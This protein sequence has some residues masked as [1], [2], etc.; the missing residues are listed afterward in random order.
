MIKQLWQ[1][2]H[3]QRWR[4]YVQVIGQW[5]AEMLIVT[6][7]CLFT[8][9]VAT[10]SWSPVLLTLLGIQLIIVIIYTFAV[11]DHL[12]NRWAQAASTE[13]QDRFFQYYLTDN[14]VDTG[15]TMKVIHQDLATI[16]GLAVFY[17]TI[18]PTTLQLI[19]TGIVM[20]VTVLYI[21]PLTVLIPLLGIVVL[22]AGMGLLEGLG[23]KK[24]LAYINSFNH[25]G[26]RFLDDFAGMKTLIMYG[27][28]KRYARNF[29]QDSETFR[30]KTMGVLVYQLQTLT[31]MDFCLYGALGWFVIAQGI[32]VH[33]Q[34]L[35]LPE[36]TLIST[37]VSIW[38]IDFRKFGYFIHI[39]M[40]L[41]PKVKHLFDLTQNTPNTVSVKT[42]GSKLPPET[43]RFRGD[44][45]Y[46][47]PLV[48]HVDLTL[49]MGT[50]TGL[51]GPSG[52]GK[53]TLAAVL[54]KQLAPLAGTVTVDDVDLATIDQRDW[55]ASAAYLGPTTV[56]FDGTIADNILL[57][58][59]AAQNWE[60]QLANRH[61]CQFVRDLP[62]G[63]HT[64]V[65][66][67]GN[68]LS[69]G[70]RQQIALARAIIADK[71]V[72]VF[73]E[74]TANVDVA[75]AELMLQAITQLAKAKIVLLITHRLD[76][77]EQLPLVNLI[78][79]NQLLAGTPAEL[80]QKVPAFKAL[81]DQQSALLKE[82]R[83]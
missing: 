21:H 39:F 23:N 77:I 5:L 17:N 33:Q 74:I 15:Q 35:T 49:K 68:R 60:S 50:I 43:I 61:L 69:Q 67:N 7:L 47:A 51:A 62:D 70:Q 19:L 31:I 55:W 81:L 26:E 41:L 1:L 53:S 10:E 28:Q 40:S 8:Y 38:L 18:I 72:Y 44:L 63:Y 22:G 14:R 32:A 42:M 9:Q 54:M 79:D 25:M 52:S 6:L 64:Q 80:T 48:S 16:K 27:R 46:D 73:D 20:V 58:N 37:L 29:A 56:L 66:E 76:D 78:D 3:T 83:A 11:S 75:N 2:G 59:P 12:S 71:S 57:S 45:G 65:G 13:L 34:A 24:N 4:T 36:A 82:V 30:Q